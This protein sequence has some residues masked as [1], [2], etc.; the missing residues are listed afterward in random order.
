[1]DMAWVA[2]RGMV[3]LVLG[4]VMALVE[5][6]WV[7]IAV[8]LL[9]VPVSRRWSIRGTRRLAATDR[10][11][12]NRCLGGAIAPG[13]AGGARWRMWRCAPSWAGSVARRWCWSGSGWR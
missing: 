11:R 3:G 5:L 9:A 2:V 6:V 10:I 12:V 7:V 4:A 13:L 1:M 8:P